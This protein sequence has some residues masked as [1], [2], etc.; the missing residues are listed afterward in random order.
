MAHRRELLHAHVL[1][2]HV[3]P[4]DIDD[5]LACDLVSTAGIWLAPRLFQRLRSCCLTSSAIPP[6]AQGR[7]PTENSGA[8]RTR[9]DTFAT[10]TPSSRRL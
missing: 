2:E 6:R 5:E 3:R 8:H 7:H 1:L 10:T 4:E 9:T